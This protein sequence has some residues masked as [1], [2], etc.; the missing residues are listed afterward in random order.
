MI[1]LI[2]KHLNKN[3]TI[4]S[5]DSSDFASDLA[6]NYNATIHEFKSGSD[7][8]TW[9]VPPEWNVNKATLSKDGK[10]IYGYKDSNLFLAPYSVPFKG[11]ISKKDLIEHTLINSKMPDSLSYEFRLPTTLKE[12]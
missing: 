2:S 3:R 12:D 4:V 8:S 10:K 11:K 5:K 6:K 9:V 1:K 7:F